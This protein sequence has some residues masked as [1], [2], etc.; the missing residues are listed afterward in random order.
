LG[1]GLNGVPAAAAE[2][3]CHVLASLKKLG[4]AFDFVLLA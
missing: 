4:S 2:F 1:N 3:L